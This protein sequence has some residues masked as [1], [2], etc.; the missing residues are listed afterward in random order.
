M[1]LITGAGS[2]PGPA[3]AGRFAAEGARVL[4]TAIDFASAA[5]VARAIGGEARA[6]RPAGS[7]ARP[8]Q[9][10]VAWAAVYLRSDESRFVTGTELRLDG[11][12]SAM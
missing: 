5:R 11:G 12:I 7:S 6:D 4:V 9:R 10:D 8:R 1:A 2:G 3:I